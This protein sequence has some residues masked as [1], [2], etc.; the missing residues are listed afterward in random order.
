VD[1]KHEMN[2]AKT[3]FGRPV[4]T[5]AQS[6]PTRPLLA[7]RRIPPRRIIVNAAVAHVHAIDDGRGPSLGS[8]PFPIWSAHE[9]G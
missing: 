2:S 8:I 9:T 4:L 7:G 3:A 1:V 5:F 6:E